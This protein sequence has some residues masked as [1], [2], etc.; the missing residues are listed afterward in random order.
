[1]DRGV[2]PMRVLRHIGLVS[3]LALATAVLRRADTQTLARISLLVIPL[4][5]IM[6]MLAMLLREY[7]NL[8]SF[9]TQFR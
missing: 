1:M 3:A 4:F 6:V 2:Y 8:A 9:A 5:L 7:M